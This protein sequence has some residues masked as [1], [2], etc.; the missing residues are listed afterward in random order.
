MKI[1]IN[2]VNCNVPNLDATTARALAAQGRFTVLPYTANTTRTL[3]VDEAIAA[4]VR[5]PVSSTRV[6]A[7]VARSTSATAP[8]ATITLNTAAAS[9]SGGFEV[10]PTPGEA[11]PNLTIHGG[12]PEHYVQ[13]GTTG[14]YVFRGGIR[15]DGS[16]MYTYNPAT[17]AF[18][19]RITGKAF[20]V[21]WSEGKGTAASYWVFVDGQPTTA[22]PVNLGASTN[23]QSAR[24]N[25]AWSTV[26]TRNVTV[27]LYHAAL[28]KVYFD[29]S[30]VQPLPAG[31]PSLMVVGDSLVE[32]TSQNTEGGAGAWPWRLARKFQLG[33][34]YNY[35]YGA[36]GLLATASGNKNSYTQ[37]WLDILTAL[38]GRKLDIGIT[39]SVFNDRAGSAGAEWQAAAAL[40]LTRMKAACVNPLFVGSADPLG[41]NGSPY[42]DCS[43]VLRSLCAAADVPY[44]DPVTGNLY[45]ADGN[46]VSKGKP[47]INSTNASLL[48]GSDQIHWTDA[49]LELVADRVG[50]AIVDLG[51]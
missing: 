12:L 21:I 27:L 7:S 2:G 28:V 23:F 48:I 34:V 5:I 32:G 25:L 3:G 20:D 9:V 22:T 38:N 51:Y 16:P 46:V 29:A 11:N 47:W 24:L 6:P 4:A 36:T 40:T 30:T 39:F 15:V 13:D 10:I 19:G 18:S 50:T 31:L 49:G 26:G 8:T 35:G 1:R 33:R 45:G 41:V 37:R 44:L 17:I 43:T 42:T 14:R